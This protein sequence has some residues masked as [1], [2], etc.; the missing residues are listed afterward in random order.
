MKLP[1]DPQLRDS[2]LEQNSKAKK[3]K[4]LAKPCDQSSQ[5]PID[6]SHFESHLNKSDQANSQTKNGELD[7]SNS[8]DKPKL[9]GEVNPSEDDG[10]DEVEPKVVGA[11]KWITG[12]DEVRQLVIEPPTGRPH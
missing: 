8:P 3:L 7:D 12:E 4:G 11:W 6:A 9:A 10:K 1:E 5:D 2:T